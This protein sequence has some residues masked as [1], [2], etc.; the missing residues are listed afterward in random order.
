MNVDLIRSIAPFSSLPEEEILYLGENLRACQYPAGTLLLQ[1]GEYAEQMFILLEGQVEIIKA[2]GTPDER[3]LAVRDK[4]SFL[5]EMSLLS[6]DGLHTASVVA[7][8]AIDLLEISRADFDAILHR[9]PSLAYEMVKTLSK[10]LDASENSTIR[11]LRRK[12][13]ELTKAY[14][15]LEAAQA[16]LV[17]QERY[18]RELELA[19]EIQRSIL[20]RSVPKVPGY[21]FGALMEPMSAVGGDLFDFIPLGDDRLGL[22]IGDVSDHGIPAA[23]YMAM[24]V[25]LLRAESSKNGTPSEILQ[26]VNRQ[27]LALNDMG[28]F[29]TILYG[30]INLINCELTYVRAGH[31]LPLIYDQRG[32][33]QEVIQGDGM[34]LGIVDNPPLDIQ[35]VRIP[36][37]GTM[38]LYSD[39]VNQATNPEG[40]LFGIE[41]VTRAVLSQRNKTAQNLCDHILEAVISFCAPTAPQDDIT[42]LA[43]RIR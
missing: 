4:I 3:L 26:N 19:R 5:G 40:R 15:E 14:R 16:Q 13:R 34:L 38:L 43:L 36:P 27:L 42:L 20:P 23:L 29:V 18:E 17:E 25:T 11:V 35:S 1:E 41:P 9:V 10:R 33:P 24:T 28:M 32:E 6:E 8:T 30:V 22:V 12:N 31:E 39:G 37:G 2:L 21:D 7:H